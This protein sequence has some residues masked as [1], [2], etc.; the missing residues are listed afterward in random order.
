MFAHALCFKK[1]LSPLFDANTWSLW[2]CHLC[3]GSLEVAGSQR[4]L[5][6]P[7]QQESAGSPRCRDG[8]GKLSSGTPQ[9]PRSVVIPTKLPME[10]NL[11]EGR[12]VP[13]LPANPLCSFSVCFSDQF[14]DRPVPRPTRDNFWMTLSGV[15]ST[16]PYQQRASLLSESFSNLSARGRPLPPLGSRAPSAPT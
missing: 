13:S 5:C 10:R 8:L 12:A 11:R 4:G 16:L 2:P 3:P 9:F 14:P 1:D 15:P 6:V 7:S